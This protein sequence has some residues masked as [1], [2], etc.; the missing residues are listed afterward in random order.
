M[1]IITSDLIRIPVLDSL[2]P[3]S[4]Q[5]PSRDRTVKVSASLDS[6]EPRLFLS[7]LVCHDLDTWVL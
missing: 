7:L 4:A 3:I 2:S 5:D 1:I 6:S